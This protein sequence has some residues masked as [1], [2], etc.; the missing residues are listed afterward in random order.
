MLWYEDGVLKGTPERV[1]DVSPSYI[2]QIEKKFGENPIPKY[3]RPRKNIHYFA[4]K[5]SKGAARI[6]ITVCA[7]DGRN[8]SHEF[9]IQN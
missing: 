8:W 4:V 7:P 6:T 5:P 2:N 1:Q 3:K 9:E